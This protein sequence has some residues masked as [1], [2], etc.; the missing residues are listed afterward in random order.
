MF[1]LSYIITGHMETIT[2]PCKVNQVVS[3]SPIKTQE[4][5]NLDGTVER[6]DG[7]LFVTLVNGWKLSINFNIDEIFFNS[8]VGQVDL[9][10][11]VMKSFWLQTFSLFWEEISAS[12]TI[13]SCQ[14]E[15]ACDRVRSKI[16]CVVWWGRH[17]CLSR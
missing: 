3:T 16:L 1:Q 12:A 5:W 4:V 2:I 14:E 10:V 17:S 6:R 7:E 15:D 8:I 13:C 11:A 9:N